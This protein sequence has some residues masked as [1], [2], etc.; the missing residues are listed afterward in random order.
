M[1]A[2][3][4]QGDCAEVL[5]GLPAASIHCAVTSP[6]YWGGVR[7]YA[8]LDDTQLGLERTPEEFVAR[9]VA[10]FEAVK[11][12]LR[13]DGVCFVNLG[14]TY[15]R[16]SHDG[17]GTVK[18]ASNSGANDAG[19]G[20][21]SD[22]QLAGVPWRFA[23]AMQAAGWR[24]R[25]SNIWAKDAPMPE[26]VSGWRW[27]Q[28]RIKRSSSARADETSYH[29]AAFG[30][31]PMGARDGRE[32]ADH[33]N[34]WQPCPGCTTCAQNGGLV[35]RRGSWRQTRSH[36]YLFQFV[37]GERYYA[38][39]IA[40][41]TPNS[42]ATLERVAYGLQSQHPSIGDID[43]KE[44]G[45][46]FAP[47][48]GANPRSVLRFPTEPLS[49][50]LCRS[51][52]RYYRRAPER[53]SCGAK[54]FVKHFAAYPTSLAEWAIKASTSEA[55]CCAE[56]GAPWARVTET[57]GLVPDQ[58]GYKP[59]GAPS[60]DGLVA[61]GMTLAGTNQ[62]APN[63][64]YE[65]RTLGWRRTCSCCILCSKDA[66]LEVD[67]AVQGQ[68]ERA[69]LLA[70]ALQPAQKGKSGI[71]KKQKARQAEV[72]K[73]LRPVPESLYGP[74]QDK[75]LLQQDMLNPLD[76]GARQSKSIPREREHEPVQ[77]AL[78]SAIVDGGQVWAGAGASSHHGGETGASVG[79]VGESTPYQRT[80][81]RQPNREPN[82]N[83]YQATRTS[84]HEVSFG[85][86]LTPPP[87]IPCT[88][89]DPF[90]G[91]G[92]SLIAATRLGRRSIGIEL[93]ADYVAL[94]RHRIADEAPQANKP[95][96]IPENA[97]VQLGLF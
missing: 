12:V 77:V 41:A 82:S 50:G 21:E 49:I 87:A 59:R 38:D 30:G 29:A 9:L 3:V 61:K 19:S 35:L 24:L 15:G 55:G 80:E 60:P 89:L 76:V 46:R 53:C 68:R 33:D 71:S 16:G 5:A 28:H 2:T 64:H 14:D 97:E 84:S 36:E 39:G 40:V 92:S 34:E 73:T 18:Q 23:L 54:D 1:T 4:H 86:P 7:H 6:P 43:T 90:C 75:P 17:A 48:G 44:M 45:S 10:I 72:S 93:S 69:G 63:H 78:P 62:P 37:K 91:S 11:R 95:D 47:S 83:D 94:A 32:F 42:E 8:G 13:E 88:V 81:E 85:H 51:C 56:C 74:G 27:E 70:T 96:S 58:P 57:L 31:K 66:S 67:G 79:D 26:S 22:G 52:G 25:A 65:S 20:G